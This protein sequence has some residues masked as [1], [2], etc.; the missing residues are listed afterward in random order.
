MSPTAL[1]RVLIDVDEMLLFVARPVVLATSHDTAPHPTL[2]A[3]PLPTPRYVCAWAEQPEVANLVSIGTSILS[4]LLTPPHC[5]HSLFQARP[6][7]RKPQVTWRQ[8][9]TRRCSAIGLVWAG[10]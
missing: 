2:P 7:S 3:T 1:S 10:R 8:A 4:S 6:A 5:L 9:T